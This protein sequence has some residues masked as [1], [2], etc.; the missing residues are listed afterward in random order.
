MLVLINRQKRIKQIIFLRCFLTKDKSSSGLKHLT[1]K[2]TVLA[3]VTHV[4][5]LVGDKLPTQLQ[6]SAKLKVLH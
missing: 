5:V 4:W 6:R 2:T 3:S 1:E